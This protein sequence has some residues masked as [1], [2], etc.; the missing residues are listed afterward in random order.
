MKILIATPARVHVM[1]PFFESLLKLIRVFEERKIIWKPLTIDHADII[2]SRNCLG[3]YFYEHQEF[4]H[5]LF[6]DADMFFEPSAILRLLD[7]DADF[8]GCACP[9]R[10]LDSR[11]V[12]EA[13]KF[14]VDNSGILDIRKALSMSYTFNTWPYRGASVS[15]DGFIRVNAIGSAITLIKRHVFGDLIARGGVKARVKPHPQPPFDMKAVYNFFDLIYLTE[16]DYISED[17]SFCHKWTK[18][19]GG[20]IWALIDE[21]IGH[22]GPYNFVGRHGDKIEVSFK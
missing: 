1:V 2:Y 6:I 19:C 15:E 4:T 7:F 16:A 20:K 3:S 12:N 21:K 14:V 11:K 9:L 8:V 18:H 22:V 10:V 5:L 17:F 13:I